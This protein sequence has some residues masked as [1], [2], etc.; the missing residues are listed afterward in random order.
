MNLIWSQIICERTY[1][2]SKFPSIVTCSSQD[3]PN[4]TATYLLQKYYFLIQNFAIL[5]SFSSG[6][7]A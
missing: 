3:M 2:L 5:R 6:K 4:I 1:H 7:S